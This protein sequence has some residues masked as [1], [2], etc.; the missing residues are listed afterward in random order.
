[1]LTRKPKKN[2]ILIYDNGFSQPEYKV[3]RF[4][5]RFPNIV[6]VENMESGEHTL[7]IWKTSSGLN[8]MVSH[9]EEINGPI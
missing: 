8:R 4:D 5:E 6:H 1:M 9:Q 3:L 7:F 2:E